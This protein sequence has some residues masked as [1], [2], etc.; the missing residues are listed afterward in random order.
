MIRVMLESGQKPST[1]CVLSCELLSKGS[2]VR[3][4]CLYSCIALNMQLACCP[5]QRHQGKQALQIRDD[6]SH[7]KYIFKP[8]LRFCVF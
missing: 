3:I 2:G 4:I 5:K 7:N 6:G 1:F 8:L